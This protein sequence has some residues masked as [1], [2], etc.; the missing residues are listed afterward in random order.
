MMFQFRTI[1][2]KML[3]TKAIQDAVYA[4][5]RDWMFKVIDEFVK[6]T[7]G[8]KTKVAFVGR[9]HGEGIANI[10]EVY[11]TN[12]IYGDVNDGT[13]KHDIWAGWYTGKSDKKVLAFPSIYSPKTKPGSLEIGEGSSGGSTVFSPYVEHPGTK[14]RDFVGQIKNKMAPVL[15]KD[16]QKAMNEGARRS[17][18]GVG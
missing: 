13:K 8:W 6:T 18:H 4:A 3:D 15:E 1:R 14:A 9:M 7:K 11:T 10:I 16:M 12:K 17:G 5:Q 2:P